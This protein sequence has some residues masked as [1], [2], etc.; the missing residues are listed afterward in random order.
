MTC[1]PK[2]KRDELLPAHPQF[3]KPECESR[4]RTVEQVMEQE[5]TG[6]LALWLKGCLV[7]KRCV[8]SCPV[9]RDLGLNS[10]IS[11]QSETSVIQTRIMRIP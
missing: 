8:P 4:A 3:Q 9:A 1:K 7:P 10:G 6:K 5:S 11:W 2:G